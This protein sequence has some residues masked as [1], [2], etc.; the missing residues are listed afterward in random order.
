MIL[1]VKTVTMCIQTWAWELYVRGLGIR[2]SKVTSYQ[3][4]ILIICLYVF[5]QYHV[6]LREDTC[7][8]DRAHATPKAVPLLSPTPP[9]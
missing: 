8:C 2:I 6:H 5:V 1:A 4:S 7:D 9:Y 3:T